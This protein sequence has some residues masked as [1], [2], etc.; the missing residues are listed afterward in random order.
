MQPT[1]APLST[2]P[3]D[4]ASPTPLDGDIVVGRRPASA[5]HTVG[6]HPGEPQFTAASREEALRLA[7]SFARKHAVDVWA[8]DGHAYR[9]LDTFRP[10]P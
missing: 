7:I 4:T 6:Q 5:A 8:R 9:R 3:R 10:G 2:A 1:R